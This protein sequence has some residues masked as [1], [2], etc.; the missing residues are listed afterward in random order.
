ML[1]IGLRFVESMERKKI[2][3]GKIA[4]G[5]TFHSAYTDE[6]LYNEAGYS[7]CYMRSLA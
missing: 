6:E 5:G 1:V 4:I 2:Q 3:R 7:I